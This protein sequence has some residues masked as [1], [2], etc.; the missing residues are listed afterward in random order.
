MSLNRAF[1]GNI[2]PQP[3][4]LITEKLKYADHL[5]LFYKHHLLHLCV[6][7]NLSLSDY[8]YSV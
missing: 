4:Y 1:Y 8:F 2:N 6:N 5:A 3:V 7:R